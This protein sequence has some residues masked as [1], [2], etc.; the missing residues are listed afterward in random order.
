MDHLPEK[1]IL[2]IMCHLV[3][4]T[5]AGQDMPEMEIKGMQHALLWMVLKFIIPG[6][7]Q[8]TLP[9]KCG[10]FN[11]IPYFRVCRYMFVLQKITSFILSGLYFDAFLPYSP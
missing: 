7:E 10:M 9:L 4:I 8:N 5:D 3:G 6:E 1:I 11:Y 2:Q